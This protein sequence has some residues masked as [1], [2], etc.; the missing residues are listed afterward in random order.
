[1]TS[2][3]PS[4][5]PSPRPS[6]G[7]PGVAVIGTGFG[8]IT[9]VRALA[10]AGFDVRALVGR[11]PAKT[12]DRAARFGIPHP[13][14]SVDEALALPGIDAVTIATPPDTHAAIASRAMRA[15]K[16]VLCE[17]PLAADA[18]EA[19]QLAAEAERAGVIHLLGAEF[20]WSSAQATMA[21]AINEGRIGSPRL[22]S[23][24]L[25]IPLLADPAAEVPDWWTDRDRGGG[26]LGAYASHL[27][28]QVRAAL[29][30]F[31][32]VSACLTNVVDRPW[33][34][35]DSYSV[36]FRLTSGVDG[37]MQSSSSDWGPIFLL[38]RVVGS[39]GTIWAEGDCVR[40]A[41]RDG[42][43]Q[44]EP[45]FGLDPTPA[46]PA[47]AELFRT[48]Y[49]LLHSL[50]QDMGPWTRMARTF[51]DLITGEPVTGPQPATFADGVALMR[52][53][54]AIRTSAA[55]GDWVTC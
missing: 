42:T 4:S 48:Q 32:A 38:T 28:D 2:S 8:C 12:R 39:A 40:V 36:Q 31:A 54:D 9:H 35:E 33:S 15:G 26:W 55:S 43:H 50:G 30:E 24:V 53:L 44:V 47:P 37:V 52:V 41:D 3:N 10:A 45:A 27:V 6:S 14:T 49:D 23:F 5:I 21:S 13:M 51:R 7:E 1:M 46:D 34:A 11:D 20:R 22:A 18:R 25:H 29:G 17:K 16:H 19:E